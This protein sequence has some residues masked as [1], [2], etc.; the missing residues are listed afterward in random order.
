VERRWNGVG[1]K[2]VAYEEVMCRS[3]ERYIRQGRNLYR[4]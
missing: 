2:G 4:L 1:R 3:L